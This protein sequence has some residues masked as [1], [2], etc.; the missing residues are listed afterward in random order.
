MRDWVFLF[1]G[2]GS[3]YVGMGRSFYESYVE[4]EKL[5][6]EASEILGRDMARLCFEGPEEELTLTKNVQPAITLVNIASLRVLELHGIRPSAVAGHSLG[7]YSALYA[8]GV[9]DMESTLTLVQHRGALMHGAAEKARG[10]MIAVMLAT[11]E[12]IA[13]LCEA[14]GVE[15]A[16]INS[17]EQTILTG[18]EEQIAMAMEESRR[19]GIRRCVPLNV[20]GP[21]HSRWMRPAAEEFGKVLDTCSL[22][23]PLIPVIM[24]VDGRELAADDNTREKLRQQL[25]SPV[26]WRQSMEHLIACG[27]RNFVEVGPKQVLSGLMRRINKAVYITNVE[28]SATLALFLKARHNNVAES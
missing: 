7:E 4:V 23:R 25:S 11:D 19:I 2:Q 13:H 15:V 9:L 27:Y 16:N 6:A 21:W 22:G 5:F 14:C 20:S 8:A 28:D 10:G 17:P 3:Q 18:T 12:Q 26:L 24:N 1:P